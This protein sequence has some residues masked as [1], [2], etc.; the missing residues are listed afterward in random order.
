MSAPKRSHDAGEFAVRGGLVD[1]FPSGAEAGAAARLLR[2]R[3]RD[4]SAPSTPPT[5][6]PPGSVDGFTLLPAS[7][8]L[9]DE[10]S[11]KRFRSALP[12]DVRRDRDRR[13]ALPG[14]QRGPPARGHGA[15][16]AAV[17][18]AAGDAVRPSRPPTPSSSATHGVAGAAEQPV[19]GDRRLSRATASSAPRQRSPAATA[20]SP[21]NALYLTADEW[22]ER[23]GRR[24]RARRHAVPRAREH[25]RRSTS[26]ST[27]RAI[28]AP[29]RSGGQQR[30]RSG[31]R[32]PRQ[33]AQATGRKPILAS[34]STGSR[35]RLT[36]LLEDHGLNGAQHRRDVAGGAGR[37]ATSATAL[38][39]LPLDHGFTAPDVAV[40]TEQDML[41]DRLVRRTKRKQVRRR[42]PRRTRHAVARR[43][44]RPRRSRHRPLRGADLDPR[45]QEPAR[46]RRAELCRRRQALRAGR[47]SRSP[48][49]ATA[50]ARKARRSTGSAA[51]RGSAAS[52]G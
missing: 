18:G 32:A 47:E 30:L 41:G 17:R 26:A 43:P 38:I 35:E 6:A 29:E 33:A 22:A 24:A 52:R 15:L 23:A 2:R 46:L 9:L 11:V 34:Y 39:V 36:G 50:R 44:R 8:A 48:H 5:S 21:A 4:A 12:R 51:R 7:E 27:A 28:S 42:L 31:R 20:R 13:S 3:D 40:L 45:R 16:A 37:R 19:R 14:D 25:D 49:R 1:L 10:D